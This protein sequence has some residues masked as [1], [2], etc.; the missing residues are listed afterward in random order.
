MKRLGYPQLLTRMCC[1]C[2]GVILCGD[3]RGHHHL[4]S[5][6]PYETAYFLKCVGIFKSAY[7]VFIAGGTLLKLQSKINVWSSVYWSETTHSPAKTYSLA[8]WWR[9]WCCRMP[10]VTRK[11]KTQPQ[12][13][14]CSGI[15]KGANKAQQQQQVSWLCARWALCSLC[16]YFNLIRELNK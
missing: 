4:S 13:S 3:Q 5:C 2:C 12:K 10:R 14:E 15:N 9:K 7:L 16:V 6:L 1:C 11:W 8:R